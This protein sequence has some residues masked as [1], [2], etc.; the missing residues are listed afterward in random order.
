MK[1]MQGHI[2]V[3]DGIRGLAILLV[4]LAHFSGEL[5]LKT[6][7]PIIGPIVTKLMLNGLLGVDLFFILSGFLI[8]GILLKTK[9]FERYFLNFYVR[10]LL[11]I[12]PLYYGVLFV[13][14]WVLPL[15]LEFDKTTQ[16]LSSNQWWL[17]LYLTNFPGHPNWDSSSIFHLGHFW[18]LAVEEHFY[19]VWP[20]VVFFCS[21]NLL[22]KICLSWTAFSMLAGL[23]SFFTDIRL[24]QFL[25]WSTISLSGSLTLGA[26]GALIAREE[27]GLEIYT[28][29]ARKW[30]LYFGV[31]L[32][33]I[34]FIPRSIGG[35]LVRFIIHYVSWG[36]VCALIILVLTSAKGS[37]LEQ[38]FTNKIMMFFG[39]L[40]YG[41]YPESVRGQ[42]SPLRFLSPGHFREKFAV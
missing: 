16:S 32:L 29:A 3:L 36:G 8:T 21:T 15:F 13:V 6:H 9:D 20:L 14:F 42:F 38:F 19:L 2:P 22:K 25:H 17:W 30:L 41:L 4:M 1:K 23:L 26:Y 24:F 27:E 18:S 11:R 33:I 37:L 12:F 34:G 39:K 40:S 35:E 31:A 5:V 7:Y 10:R 28:V